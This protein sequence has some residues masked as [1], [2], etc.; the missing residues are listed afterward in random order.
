MA[1]IEVAYYYIDYYIDGQ[2]YFIDLFTCTWMNS[3][4]LVSLCMNISLFIN[5]FSCANTCTKVFHATHI[6][7]WV[8]LLVVF[9]T[10]CTLFTV[11]TMK[12]CENLMM[13]LLMSAFT[14]Y[15]Y[16]SVLSHNQ[17][18]GH[19]VLSIVMAM[20]LFLRHGHYYR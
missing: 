2:W 1:I 10:R 14:N 3:F 5:T 20:A 18:W 15:V 19:E 17:W 7:C 4:L 16:Y 11:F 8:A 12:Q 13:K 9:Y 6:L